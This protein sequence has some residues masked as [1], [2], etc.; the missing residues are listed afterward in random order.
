MANKCELELCDHMDKI[1][2][3]IGNVKYISDFI[4]SLKFFG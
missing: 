3:M 4:Q 2:A 1:K